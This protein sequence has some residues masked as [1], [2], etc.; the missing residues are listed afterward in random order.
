MGATLVVRHTDSS[1]PAWPTGSSLAIWVRHAKCTLLA[2]AYRVI[3]C[4]PRDK[5][6]EVVILLLMLIH[7]ETHYA[8]R[9]LCCPDSSSVCLARH[10]TGSTRCPAGSSA[11]T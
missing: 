11:K 1:A 5:C 6:Y 4:V 9:L 7:K 3:P 8:T 10:D 2:V